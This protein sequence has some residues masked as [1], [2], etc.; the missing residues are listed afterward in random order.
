MQTVTTT[1]DEFLPQ[2]VPAPRVI[3]VTRAPQ[4]TRRGSKT[5]LA[6]SIAGFLVMLGGPAR[7]MW[8]NVSEIG[9]GPIVAEAAAPA[10]VEAAAIC[11]ASALQMQVAWAPVNNKA[12]DGYEV[13]RVGAPG[14][15]I[16]FTFISGG[17]TDGFADSTVATGSSYRYEVRT[18]AGGM[19]GEIATSSPATTPAGC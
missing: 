19:R 3:D 15:P 5:L 8:S 16:V 17:S 7:A 18:M 6:L 9:T 11:S 14:E 12:V 2:I 4:S 10:S 1:Q 13:R